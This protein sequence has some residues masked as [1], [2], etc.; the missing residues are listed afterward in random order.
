M[1]LS[2]GKKFIWFL[3][4]GCVFIN[5]LNYETLKILQSYNI[6]KQLFNIHSSKIPYSVIIGGVGKDIDPIHIKSLIAKLVDLGKSFQKFHI[7]IYENNSSEKSRQMWRD[8][9]NAH[10]DYST[11][12][13]EDI[14]ENKYKNKKLRTFKIARARNSFMENIHNNSV[15]SKY[16]YIIQT[17]L[18]RVCG[19]LNPLISFNVTVFKNG[20]MLNREWEALSFRVAPYWDRWA[21]RHHE[22]MPVNMWSSSKTKRKKNIIKNLVDMELFLNKQ[23]VHSLVEVE[24]AYMMLSIYKMKSTFQCKYNN[25]DENGEQDCEHVSF[26]RSMQRMH[27]ARIRILPQNQCED[28]SLKGVEMKNLDFTTQREAK[29]PQNCFNESFKQTTQCR[30]FYWTF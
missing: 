7:V 19:G 3:L 20:F 4:Y 27:N 15:L 13:S 22:L 21:F 23:D 25:L 26:H 9:L 2:K 1:K 17:D 6:N 14:D 11:L 8:T 28:P 24:S 30:P 18:D 12:I 16:D 5:I 10:G 29:V